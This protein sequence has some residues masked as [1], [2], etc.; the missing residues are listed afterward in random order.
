MATSVV[1]LNINISI[2]GIFNW[3]GEV[4]DF[5]LTILNERLPPF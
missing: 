5:N 2:S 4:N 3:V 1:F